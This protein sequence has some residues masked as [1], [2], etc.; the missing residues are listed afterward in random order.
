[1][2]GTLSMDICDLFYLRKFDEARSPV[3]GSRR[4]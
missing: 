3:E 1:M 4:L 2:A